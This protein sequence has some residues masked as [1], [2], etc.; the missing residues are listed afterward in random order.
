MLVFGGV[1][2]LQIGDQVR[3]RLESQGTPFF[4]TITTTGAFSPEAGA[5]S[6]TWY[7]QNGD[8]FG[9]AKIDFLGGMDVMDFGD[10]VGNKINLKSEGIHRFLGGQAKIDSILP[11]SYVTK[12]GK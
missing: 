10:F 5:S 11:A 12:S 3:S 6:S 7:S 4:F 1:S 9:G 8:T 2:D